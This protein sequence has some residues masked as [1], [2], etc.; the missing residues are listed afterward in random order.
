M[1]IHMLAGSDTDME[2]EEGKTEK[3]LHVVIRTRAKE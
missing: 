3:L 2:G 1:Y